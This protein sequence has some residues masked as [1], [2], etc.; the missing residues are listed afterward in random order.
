MTLSVRIRAAT[1]HD[2]PLLAAIERAAAVR[3]SP[4][5]LPPAL[6]EQATSPKAFETGWRGGLLW[7]ADIA[8]GHAEAELDT[9]HAE[10]D[11][12]AASPALAGFALA[13]VYGDWLHLKEMSVHPDHGRL[14]IGRS[15]LDVVIAEAAARRLRGVTLTTFAHVPWNAPFYAKAGFRVADAPESPAHLRARLVREREAGLRN[16]TGMWR[17]G[18]MP[19][20]RD[21]PAGGEPGAA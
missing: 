9:G 2:L 8:T 6:R 13:A 19:G 11:T 20:T 10:A 3:F 14:G 4:D 7:V 1:S 17:D 15:L 21:T 18:R 5:D 12:A 16:R